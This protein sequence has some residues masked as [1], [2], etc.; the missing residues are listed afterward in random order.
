[1]N[2]IEYI[3]ESTFW[4]RLSQTKNIDN[5]AEV[6][7][8]IQNIKK[9]SPEEIKEAEEALNKIREGKWQETILTDKHIEKLKLY[10]ISKGSASH[11][12]FDK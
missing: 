3:G 5:K 1:M 10:G 2:T 12:K 9:M 8:I 6:I 7:R 4:Q 11:P